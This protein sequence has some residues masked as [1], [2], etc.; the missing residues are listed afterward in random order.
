MHMEISSSEHKEKRGGQKTRPGE[1][2][3]AFTFQQDVDLCN[4]FLVLKC[5]VADDLF[6]YPTII[7]ASC[8][9]ITRHDLS[10]LKHLI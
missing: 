7:V 3:D 9:G 5:L 6:I 2:G 1:I 10:H 8:Q 4:N